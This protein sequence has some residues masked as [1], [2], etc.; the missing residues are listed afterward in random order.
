MKRVVEVKC[1]NC[2]R[3]YR[4]MARTLSQ[5]ARKIEE[6]GW[7]AFFKTPLGKKR[8]IPWH[9]VCAGCVRPLGPKCGSLRFVKE[10]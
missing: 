2:Q 10:A 6:H 4:V 9:V 3:T 7:T 1:G 5:V 8:S